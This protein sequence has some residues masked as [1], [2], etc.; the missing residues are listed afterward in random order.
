MTGLAA[1]RRQC[2]AVVPGANICMTFAIPGIIELMPP[3]LHPA[4]GSPAVAHGAAEDVGVAAS[5]ISGNA[6][7]PPRA[8][9][10]GTRMTTARGNL[11]DRSVAD[12]PQNPFRICAGPALMQPNRKAREMQRLRPFSAKDE[13]DSLHAGTECPVNAP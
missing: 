1:V 3:P 8:A 4:A 11:E 5:S 12:I 7:Q 13:I 6:T 2:E 9:N 10:S